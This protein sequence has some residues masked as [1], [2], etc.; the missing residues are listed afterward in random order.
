[1][2][3]VKVCFFCGF[4]FFVGECIE[5]EIIF[6]NIVSVEKEICNLMCYYILD[7]ECIN[8]KCEM[9]RLVWVSV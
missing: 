7:S 3:E 9:D 6:M 1:M 4:V 8:E 5:C 2:I